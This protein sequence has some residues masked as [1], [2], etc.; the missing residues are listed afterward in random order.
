M[1]ENPGLMD[2]FI[3]Y[4]RETGYQRIGL[5]YGKYE[6]Y[7]DVPLGIKA[8]V[9]AIYEPPQVN[10]PTCRKFSKKIL[11]F[12]DLLHKGLS[13]NYVIHVSR[14]FDPPPCYHLPDQGF[15]LGLLDGGGA[16]FSFQP[17]I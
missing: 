17:P 14:I 15:P 3:Q 6:H 11:T 10:S 12:R 8:T 5:L 16:H 7:K 1:F 2:R 13:I 9:A 4:W